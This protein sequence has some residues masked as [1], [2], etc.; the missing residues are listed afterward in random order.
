MGCYLDATVWTVYMQEEDSPSV[1]SQVIHSAAP[2]V[3][4][5]LNPQGIFYTFVKQTEKLLVNLRSALS[6][7]S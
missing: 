4:N 7:K 3:Q 5:C 1:K 6:H 2:V